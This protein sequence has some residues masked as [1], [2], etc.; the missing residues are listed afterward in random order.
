MSNIR[1]FVRLFN[2]LKVFGVVFRMVF[3]FS[4]RF[5]RAFGDGRAN[6][7]EGFRSEYTA[8]GEGFEPRIATIWHHLPP[9]GA[10][11]RLPFA[12]PTGQALVNRWSFY[13]RTKASRARGGPKTAKTGLA[14]LNQL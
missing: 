12:S 13:A 2:G 10:R 4:G 3:A 1:K 14:Q 9:S 8:L 5:R 6:S 7:A 11:I